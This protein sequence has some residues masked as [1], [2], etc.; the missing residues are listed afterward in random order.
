MLA[1]YIKLLQDLPELPEVKGENNGILLWVIS[2]LIVFIIAMFFHFKSEIKNLKEE[3]KEERKYNRNQDVKN[4]GLIE[5]VNV[6]LEQVVKLLDKN[7]DNMTGIKTIVDGINPII[8]KNAERL[9]TIKDKI[10]SNE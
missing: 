4:I 6:T 2:V 9:E 5:I 1:Y 10:I 8:K 7:I 3:L